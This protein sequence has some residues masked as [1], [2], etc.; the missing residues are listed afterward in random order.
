MIIKE[1]H[2]YDLTHSS[3]NMLVIS[4]VK[5]LT[6]KIGFDEVSQSLIASAA[7]EL[8]T[9]IIRYAKTGTLTINY[10]TS[11]NKEGVQIIAEDRGPGIENLENALT[12]H[13]T[14]GC[15]LGLGLPSVKRIMDEFSIISNPGDGTE[16][17]VVKWR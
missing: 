12:E 14:T 5:H 4:A 8:S 15:S 3:D 2:I 17:K 11:F 7:S 1:N 16:I 13:F 10:I 6:S 9:N